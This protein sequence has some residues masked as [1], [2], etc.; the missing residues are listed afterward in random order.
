MKQIE[1]DAACLLL[2]FV[3]E[4]FEEFDNYA[5]A[6]GFDDRV[7]MDAVKALKGTEND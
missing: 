2:E 1:N 5:A 7:V 6:N 4:Y 3:T